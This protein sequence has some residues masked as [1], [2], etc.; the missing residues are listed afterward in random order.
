MIENN[1]ITDKVPDEIS[2]SNGLDYYIP[3]IYNA[4]EILFNNIDLGRVSKT[5]IYDSLGEMTY[6]E[7]CDTAS[8][9]GNALTSLGLPKFSRVLMLL[10]DTRAYP[11]AIFGAMRAGFVPVLINT[12]SP[13]DL[14]QYY[15]EDSGA[16]VAFV[17]SQFLQLLTTDSISNTQLKTVIVVNG[18]STSLSRVECFY[19]DDWLN[20]ES[21]HLEV[22]N[23]CLLYTSD[24]A[25]E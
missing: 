17:D 24:A 15:L 12:L 23:T 8:Q 19:W 25:D 1:D 11:A 3:D 5:A 21:I 6:G 18:K 13:S 22:V 16:T 2:A 10:D 7:L 20:K 9:V 4:S 14:I